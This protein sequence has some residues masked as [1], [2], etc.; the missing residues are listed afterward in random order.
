MILIVDSL[1]VKILVGL[2][3]LC[4]WTKGMYIGVVVLLCQKSKAESLWEDIALI[5]LKQN[6]IIINTKS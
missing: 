3:V 5:I 1:I 6:L 4:R 2:A